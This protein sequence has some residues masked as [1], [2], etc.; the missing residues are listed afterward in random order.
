M[1]LVSCK[2]DG[3]MGGGLFLRWRWLLPPRDASSPDPSVA[4]H[5][6]IHH[7]RLLADGTSAGPTT[8]E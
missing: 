6:L 2:S 4:F 7:R 3:E 5:L 8:P 1:R